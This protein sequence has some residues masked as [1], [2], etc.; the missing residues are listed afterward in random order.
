MAATRMAH[1]PKPKGEKMLFCSHEKKPNPPARRGCGSRQLS[2]HINPLTLSR[3]LLGPVSCW[4]L[5]GSKG[6]CSAPPAKVGARTRSGH[7][8]N[9]LGQLSAEAVPELFLVA[10]PSRARPMVPPGPTSHDQGK[11]TRTEKPSTRVASSLE[12]QFCLLDSALPFK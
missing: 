10:P 7:R 6:G 9:V 2:Q 8:Y 1:F 3:K 4:L 12:A 11:V 5:H